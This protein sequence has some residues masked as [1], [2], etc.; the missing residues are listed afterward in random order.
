MHPDLL[1]THSCMS[2][3]RRWRIDS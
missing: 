3:G 1:L 2:L